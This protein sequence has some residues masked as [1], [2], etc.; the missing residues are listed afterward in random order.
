M[1]LVGGFLGF[2]WGGGVCWLLFQKKKVFCL[3]DTSI[4]FYFL[5]AL[6]V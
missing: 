2:F 4:L 5:N 1:C 3:F 6:R